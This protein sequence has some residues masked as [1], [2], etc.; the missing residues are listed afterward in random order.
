MRYIYTY[1]TCYTY[2][3]ATPAIHMHI[4]NVRYIYTYNTS[5]RL[6]ADV[7]V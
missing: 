1:N 3:H 4:E 6:D 5:E 7:V 2:T